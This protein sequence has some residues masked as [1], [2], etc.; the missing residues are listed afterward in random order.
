MKKR[1]LFRYHEID[2][3]S[4]NTVDN[5]MCIGT[6]YYTLPGLIVTITTLCI[7]T[8]FYTMQLTTFYT[9]V[10]LIFKQFHA[11]DA[12][13]ALFLTTIPQIL[14]AIITPF[15]SFKSD[16][17]RSKLGRRIPYL[18]WGGPVVTIF[19]IAIGWVY[20]ISSELMDVFQWLPSYF[21][22]ILLGILV[23]G[24]QISFL[25]IGSII[26]YFFPDVIPP[27]Y[28]GRFMALFQLSG[29]LAGFIFSR[30][31]LKYVEGYMGWL[32]T[33]VGLAFF[34]SMLIVIFTVQ[35]GSYRTINT[36]IGPPSFWHTIKIYFKECYSIPFYYSFF[37]MMALSDASLITRGMF[38]LIYARDTLGIPVEQFGIMTGWGCLVGVLL[39]FPV[40]LL[41]DKLGAL[42]VFAI[43]TITV[44]LV[45]FFS[46][47][48]VTGYI[49]FYISTIALAI[50][51][52]IQSTSSLPVFV[53]ILPKDFYGQFSSA[54]AL[55]R[56]VFVAIIGFGGGI[57][58]DIL[59][60]Y[61]YIFAWDF[62]FTFLS[63]LCFV[64]LYTDWKKLGGKNYYTAPIYKG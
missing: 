28:I 62:I 44:I 61:Q 56:A 24:Y 49:S 2:D 37:A 9:V 15:I 10:P 25:I 57:L 60:D 48:W 21:P 19:L 51:Y 30:Y 27:K 33:G 59:Q 11:A 50:V 43:G 34:I 29:S 26:Y 16:R 12:L 17:C 7:G 35:E 22:I 47:F 31:F 42:K 52:C 58:F 63:F 4:D 3:V 8:C 32:F 1:L 41:T 64:K 36:D 55:V 18:L 46:F 39:G 5:D 20:Q 38:N 13:I 53:A 23:I 6:L 45:N 54:N 40:G 14:N